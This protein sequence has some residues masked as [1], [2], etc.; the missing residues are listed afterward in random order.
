MVQYFIDRITINFD[1]HTVKANIC[2][3]NSF[4]TYKHTYTYVQ[5]MYSCWAVI[6]VTMYI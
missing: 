6:N 4:D 5:Y 3:N 1:V 2:L